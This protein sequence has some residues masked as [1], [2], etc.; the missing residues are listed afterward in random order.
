[1]KPVINLPAVSAARK[2]HPLP[3]TPPSQPGVRLEFVAFS[4]SADKPAHA[5]AAYAAARLLAS[6]NGSQGLDVYF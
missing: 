2:I 5:H 3:L 4:S 1:M 6:H